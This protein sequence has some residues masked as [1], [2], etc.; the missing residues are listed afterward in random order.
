MQWRQNK[1]QNIADNINNVRFEAS[2]QFRD[3]KKEYLKC[4]I[5]E[6]KTNSDIIKKYK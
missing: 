5:D 6:L 2:G 4:K 1:N 3:Q